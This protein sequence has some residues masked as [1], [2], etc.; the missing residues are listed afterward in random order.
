MPDPTPPPPPGQQP[1]DEPPAPR[2]ESTVSHYPDVIVGRPVG[3][4]PLLLDLTVPDHATPAP[5]V[6]HIYGG[7]FATGSRK[8]SPLGRYLAGRL[9]DAGF[10]LAHV[11][12]RHSREAP[13]PA[14]LHDL[15]AA[16]RWLRR[17]STALGVDPTRFAAWG[18]SSGG[19]LAT[20]LAVTGDRPDLDGVVGLTG[21]SGAVQA[22]VSWNAPVDL[23][24]LPPP[25]AESPFHRLGEDPHDW[26]V[27]APVTARP[28]LA[29]AASTS[30]YPTADAAPLLLAHGELDDVIPIDHSEQIA[31]A[32]AAAGADAELVRV[33][34]AGHS[35]ADPDRER[36]VT[37]GIDFLRR[38]LLDEPRAHPG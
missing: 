35:F 15:K 9:P 30:T 26:L 37:A 16:V 22:A 2:R 38:R 28:D 36:L 27:G 33:P 31:A 23:A 6:I 8:H 3:Y 12:H 17:H 1:P 34:G 20:M 32:Y 14:Q 11:E 19:H 24:R 4:R 21:V 25:P 13:F 10:A 18:T 29:A 5:L 7:A